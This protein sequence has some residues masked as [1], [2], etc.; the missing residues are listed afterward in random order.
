M[1]V[2]KQYAGDKKAKLHELFNLGKFKQSVYFLDSE[3]I[4]W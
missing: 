4:G 2:A 3:H 1:A